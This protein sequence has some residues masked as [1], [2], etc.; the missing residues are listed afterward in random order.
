[1]FTDWI[2][3]ISQTLTKRLKITKKEPR[4]QWPIEIPLPATKSSMLTDLK[5]LTR[6]AHDGF[7]RVFFSHSIRGPVGRS[8]SD[9]LK[10]PLIDMMYYCRSSVP[11]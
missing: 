5:L 2:G 10:T 6:S 8:N 4:L 7:E 1:M 9:G 3:L 11:G